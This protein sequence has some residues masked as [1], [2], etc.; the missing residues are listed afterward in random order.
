V[1]G[2]GSMSR[3][4]YMEGVFLATVAAGLSAFC[5]ATNRA[6]IGAFGAFV[7]GLLV[8]IMIAEAAQS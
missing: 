3:G 8:G 4:W 1:E 5:L 7:F 6:A 2:N